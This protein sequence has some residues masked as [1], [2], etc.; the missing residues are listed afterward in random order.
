MRQKQNIAHRGVIPY[1]S[2]PQLGRRRDFACCWRWNARGE[3]AEA[4]SR[5]TI[6][7]DGKTIL[8]VHQLNTRRG[9][10]S[11][12]DCAGDGRPRLNPSN[13]NEIL[14]R[15][16]KVRNSLKIWDRFGRRWY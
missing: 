7:V 8:Q 1:H 9:E 13:H 16:V 10:V 11:T 5:S 4:L 14:T 12:Y 15:L 6:Q 3:I 2:L